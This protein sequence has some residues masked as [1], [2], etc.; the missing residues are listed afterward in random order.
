MDERER[1]EELKEEPQSE[2]GAPG[3]RDRGEGPDGG[4]VN[5]PTGESE[6]DSDT[7][8]DPQ[9]TVDEESPDMPTGP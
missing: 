7:G 8:V 5:R 6:H 2:R 4:L 9:E 3:S 1:S